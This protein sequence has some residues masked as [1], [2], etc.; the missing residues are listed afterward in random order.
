MSDK[1]QEETV[2]DEIMAGT[3]QDVYLSDL[4]IAAAARLILEA[5][6]ERDALRVE[7]SGRSHVQAMTQR[8]LERVERERDAA[9]A[10]AK[11]LEAELL[12]L[13][14]AIRGVK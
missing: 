11:G 5:R 10:W 4:G 8:D 6:R 9:L 13:C 7:V 12:D 3:G 2:L 14:A 1:Q